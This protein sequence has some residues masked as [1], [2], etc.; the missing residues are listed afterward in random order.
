MVAQDCQYTCNPAGWVIFQYAFQDL[1][2]QVWNA[3]ECLIFFIQNI[4]QPTLQLYKLIFLTSWHATTLL[5][6][7]RI[8]ILMTDIASGTQWWQNTK[9][10]SRFESGPNWQSDWRMSACTTF[11][12]ALIVWCHFCG[13]TTLLSPTRALS[14]LKRETLHRAKSPANVMYIRHFNGTAKETNLLLCDKTVVLYNSCQ[15]ST[16]FQCCKYPWGSNSSKCMTRNNKKK[17][18]SE[19]RVQGKQRSQHFDHVWWTAKRQNQSTISNLKVTL[20]KC[21]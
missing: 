11:P 12:R 4:H 20:L 13:Q 6:F 2:L 15:S 21:S 14:T 17:C 10:I 7:Y 18:S 3:E 19:E 9:K 16:H 5:T 1:V 8:C